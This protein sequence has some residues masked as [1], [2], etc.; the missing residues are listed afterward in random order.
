MQLLATRLGT[1][2]EEI[3]AR[4]GA[5]CIQ[6]I[7]AERGAPGSCL[8]SADPPEER[9]VRGDAF[10]MLLNVPWVCWLYSFSMRGACVMLF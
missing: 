6:L 4:Q 3:L 2:T 7:Y 8:Y 9:T 5:A 1:T 10:L